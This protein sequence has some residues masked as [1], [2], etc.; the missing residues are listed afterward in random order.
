[1]HRIREIKSAL[2]LTT[3][4]ESHVGRRFCGK[5]GF[6]PESRVP[7]D[8]STLAQSATSAFSLKRRP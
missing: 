7:Q 2:E 1:M 5:S 8:G 3:L 6:F 4:L